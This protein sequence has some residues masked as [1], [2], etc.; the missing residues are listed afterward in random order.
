MRERRV[1]VRGN[2]QWGHGVARIQAMIDAVH[3]LVVAGGVTLSALDPLELVDVTDGDTPRAPDARPHA[4]GRQPR[5]HRPH[6]P[7]GSGHRPGA[8]T[9]GQLDWPGACADLPAV[10]DFLVPKLANRACRPPSAGRDVVG[11]R[12]GPQRPILD[13]QGSLL[14]YLA[15]GAACSVTPTRAWLRRSQRSAGHWSLPTSNQVTSSPLPLTGI[16]PRRSSR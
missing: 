5:G 2:R 9:T 4:V 14:G 7:T 12:P 1:S 8:R 15:D 6:R 3:I 16:G 11:G 10:A 13:T